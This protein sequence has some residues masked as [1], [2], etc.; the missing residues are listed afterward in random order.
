MKR[1]Y[2]FFKRLFDFCV[3]LITLTF[4]SPVLILIM[5]I[6]WATG[7]H[8]VF[9]FQTRM[10]YKNKPFKIWKFATMLK[11]SINM[12]T[13]TITLPGDTRVLPFG[14]FLRYTKINELPQLI[15]ILKGD[16][17][18]VGPRPVLEKGWMKFPEEL[19]HQ[20]Y[21]VKPGLTGLGSV[22][23]R[24][25]SGFVAKQGGTPDTVFR[26]TVFPY[27]GALEIYYQ[28]NASMWADFKIMFLTA[29]VI[30]FP[31]SQLQSKLFKNLPKPLK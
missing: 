27:K 26:E 4:L 9:Y 30:V 23:F 14:R 8:E 3:S 18:F 11:G 6:L 29:W 15:N 16:M 7:E 31:K 13:G 5:L 10:G 1:T 12:G 17:S 25:E 2:L 20:I 28:N 24:D 21:N 22:V 19:R